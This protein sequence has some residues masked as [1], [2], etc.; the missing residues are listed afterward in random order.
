[1]FQPFY[2]YIL[3]RINSPYQWLWITIPRLWVGSSTAQ[4]ICVSYDKLREREK[5]VCWT[6]TVK[7]S[8]LQL[9]IINS[10]FL[11]R[12]S[13]FFSSFNIW[14]S[15]SILSQWIKLHAESMAEQSFCFFRRGF[16]KRRKRYEN[17]K[18]DWEKK[19]RFLLAARK[20]LLISSILVFRV[21]FLLGFRSG[22]HKYKFLWHDIP[23][24]S[25]AVVFLNNAYDKQLRFRNYSYLTAIL[26]AL[27]LCVGET[28][29]NM[30]IEW[31]NISHTWEYINWSICYLFYY[32]CESPCEKWKPIYPKSVAIS[33][34]DWV[35]NSEMHDYPKYVVFVFGDRIIIHNFPRQSYTQ[36]SVKCIS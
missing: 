22:M 21:L 33:Q 9:S 4:H 30:W 10:S 19:P 8:N 15:F 14:Y 36:L 11:A 32:H 6:R 3:L 12:Q 7:S 35:L 24:Q 20:T 1:M 16:W 28:W 2:L 34:Y 18:W 23:R 13:L 25:C 29:I 5:K 17:C 27:D 31:K 26:I